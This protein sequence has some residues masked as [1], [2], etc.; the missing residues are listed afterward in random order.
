V[1]LVVGTSGVVQPAA[2]LPFVAAQHGA[3]VIEVN[4]EVSLIT[5]L[6]KWHLAGPSGQILPQVIDAMPDRSSHA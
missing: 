5:S 4:P 6:A 1:A 2:S 3:T